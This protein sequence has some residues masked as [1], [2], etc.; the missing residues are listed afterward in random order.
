MQQNDSRR[1][2]PRSTQMPSSRS[3]SA[4]T[5]CRLARSRS[6]SLPAANSSSERIPGDRCC[7]TGQNGVYHD[8]LEAL[9]GGRSHTARLVRG[10]SG[11]HLAALC[12]DEDRA[13]AAA[14]R[15]H[16]RLPH[17]AR[18]RPRADRRHRLVVDRLP[19]LQPPPHPAGGRAAARSDAACD[20][21]RAGARGRADAG[22]TARGAAARR[23]R[24]GVLLRLRL[25]GGRGRHEDGGAILAQP[26][27]P[28]PHP[29]HRLQG[30]L[31]RRHVR[32]DGG[33]R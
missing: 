3:V 19:R 13:A 16:R 14:G 28:R 17:H 2:P 15:A 4:S 9:N 6:P 20:V 18:R 8:G 27:R 1:R 11:A 12:A 33:E 26:G 25:G 5:R 24:S 30:R 22:A 32:R 31:S 10:R 21:R 23:S 7:R 29:V